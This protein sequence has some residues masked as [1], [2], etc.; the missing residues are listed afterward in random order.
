MWQCFQ[1]LE[2]KTRL[3]GIPNSISTCQR[4]CILNVVGVPN[5]TPTFRL[6][7]PTDSSSASSDS[8]RVGG[9]GCGISRGVRVYVVAR[10]CRK[11]R[12]SRL[13]IVGVRRGRGWRGRVC[14]RARARLEWDDVWDGT[15]VPAKVVR[16]PTVSARRSKT[17]RT[18]CHRGLSS[19]SAV[20][21]PFA[22]RGLSR[23]PR[24]ARTESTCSFLL[25]LT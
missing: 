21:C 5:R 7:P 18:G 19:F 17:R 8:D 6:S 20:A 22:R 23:V 4:L 9:A 2:R 25:V 13:R 12:G 14:E 16:G 15:V 10:E 11:S 1:N 24:S 3:V